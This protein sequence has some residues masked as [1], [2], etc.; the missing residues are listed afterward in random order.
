MI[1]PEPVAMGCAAGIEDER[2]GRTKPVLIP[3]LSRVDSTQH[4]HEVRSLVGVP[5][6]LAIGDRCIE[7]RECK[8][9]CVDVPAGVAEKPAGRQDRC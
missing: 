6:H 5:W 4:E 2:P 7:L 9:V 1:S 3:R 8:R